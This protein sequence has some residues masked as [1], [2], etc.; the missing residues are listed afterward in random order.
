MRRLS[1][2]TTSTHTRAFGD[3]IRRMASCGTEVQKGGDY[4]EHRSSLRRFGS[5]VQDASCRQGVLA[6]QLKTL[7]CEKLEFMI[8]VEQN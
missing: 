1:L 7:L 5:Q 2:E 6:E 4:A 8:K 3:I